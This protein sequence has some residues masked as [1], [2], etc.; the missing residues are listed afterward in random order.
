M[1]G[2]AE[3]TV[4]DPLSFASAEAARAAWRP[5]ED[6]PEVELAPSEGVLSNAPQLR[7]PAP[8]ASADIRRAVVDRAVDMDLGRYGRFTLE[9]RT[10]HP[11]A[12]S[13]F[14]LYFRSG[15]GWYGGN[16]VVRGDGWQKLTFH[17]ADFIPEDQPEGWHRVTGIRLSG[18]KAG[19]VDTWMDVRAL[20][21]VACPY[22]VVQPAFAGRDHPEARSAREYARSTVKLLRRVGLD[23]DVVDQRDLTRDVLRGRTI[24]LLPY[25][26]A[27]SED[28]LRALVAFARGGGKLG[29]F[30]TLDEPL[31]EALGLRDVEW[32]QAARQGEFHSIVFDA[33]AVPGLPERL[34][35]ASWN[36]TIAYPGEGAGTVI[37]RWADRDGEV[38]DAAAVVVGPQGFFMGHVLTAPDPEA[39]A[40]LLLALIGRFAPAA[41]EEAARAVLEQAPGIGHLPTGDEA[42]AYVN[43]AMGSAAGRGSAASFLGQAT[44]SRR[45]ADEA[46]ATGRWLDVIR[47][48]Q[49]SLE[50]MREAY[51]RSH[52][53]RPVEARAVWNHSGTGI[54]P[55][56][57]EASIILLRGLNL[58]MVI[59]NMWWGGIAHYDS[60][61]LPHSRTFERYGDQIEQCVAAARRHGIEVH[62]WKVNWNLL[63]A[64]DD[65]V[66]AMRRD[67]RTQVSNTG[68]PIDWLCPSHPDNFRLE[69]ETMLEVVRNYDVDGV[70]F[71]YIRYP[72]RQ[73]CYCDGC[74]ERFEAQK[75]EPV[76][77]WPEDVYDGRLRGEYVDWRCEQITRLVR[78][79]ARQSRAMKPGVKISAAVFGDY[80]SCRS[81]IGQDWVHWV[82][83]G[84]LDF[85]CPMDYTND[86]GRFVNLVKRQV[87]LVGERVP[88]Y[89]G[90]GATSSQSHLAADRIAG[91]VFLSRE[92]GADGFV[93]F[94]FGTGL[95]DPSEP[96]TRSPLFGCRRAILAGPAR[97]PHAIPE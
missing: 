45:K 8:F 30:Y 40:Q 15:D 42:A 19:D 95:L 26:P 85:V 35:Q 3:E 76:E 23:P 68:E 78:E 44:E 75:G 16:A 24:A 73:G 67:G 97:P 13:N 66:E 80:P 53:S 21:G 65:F 60:A 72:G 28:E 34:V 9:V 6:A 47:F 12:F 58:N 20:K 91:Q 33:D 4:L 43:D 27:L 84:Y 7:L 81:S 82:K 93:I 56:D 5:D 92:C 96:L 48:Q 55:G 2:S 88:L 94:N 63:N 10:P 52:A 69:L 31:A 49:A 89:A 79:T 71:D 70:H 64:P 11:S 57:W 87:T 83:E 74:R 86:D 90:I 54:I 22:A 50:S 17:R 36:T 62:P 14:T 46:F 29:V 77:S 59:P 1:N 61:L 41:W 37:G 18:W 25:N 51:M 38:S 32:R 39:K